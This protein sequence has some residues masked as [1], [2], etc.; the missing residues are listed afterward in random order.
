MTAYANIYAEVVAPIGIGKYTDLT[1]NQTIVGQT[2]VSGTAA[3]FTVKGSSLNTFNV[4]LPVK[5]MI[6]NTIADYMTVSDFTSTTSTADAFQNNSWVISIAATLKL[7][8][9]QA[10]GNYCVQDSFQVTLNYN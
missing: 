5:E 10:A 2:G 7:N 3:S 6:I 4:T 9:T 1:I 8:G